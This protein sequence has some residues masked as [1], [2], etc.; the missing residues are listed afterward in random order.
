MIRFYTIAHDKLRAWEIAAGSVAPRAAGRVHSDMEE[1]FIRARVAR[2]DDVVRAGGLAAL[3]SEGK[4]RI[5]G[6]E[7]EVQDGDVLEFRF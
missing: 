5:E 1:G 7:Y 2:W 4:I 3:A 6:K